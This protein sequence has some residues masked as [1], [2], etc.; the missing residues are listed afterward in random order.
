[1]RTLLDAARP[2]ASGFRPAEQRPCRALTGITSESTDVWLRPIPEVL[3]GPVGPVEPG[4]VA[5]RRVRQRRPLDH[6]T[7]GVRCRKTYSPW[8]TRV[9]PSSRRVDQRAVPDLRAKSAPSVAAGHRRTAGRR[10]DGAQF[11]PVI[12]RIRVPRVDRRPCPHP[13]GPD[14]GRQ[15]LPEDQPCLPASTRSRPLSTS[16]AIRPATAGPKAHTEDGHRRLTSGYK[17]APRGRFGSQPVQAAARDSDRYGRS[18]FWSAWS[19]KSP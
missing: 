14:T 18:S 11:T 5:D 10:G 17:G 1:M 9:V 4:Q 7:P 2:V 19:T 16:C 13:S 8:S 15:G 12:E 3:L 6:S